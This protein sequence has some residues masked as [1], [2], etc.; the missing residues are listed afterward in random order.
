M[1][2]FLPTE[3]WLIAQKKICYILKFLYNHMLLKNNS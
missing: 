1:G 2:H 3:K